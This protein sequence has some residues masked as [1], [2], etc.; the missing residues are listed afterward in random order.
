MYCPGPWMARRT[1]AP[2]AASAMSCRCVS[3]HRQRA[4]RRYEEA[5]AKQ[6]QRARRHASRRSNSEWSITWPPERTVLRE[7]SGLGWGLGIRVEEPPELRC[8]PGQ[9]LFPVLASTFSPRP[10]PFAQHRRVAAARL[11]LAESKGAR[12]RPSSVRRE[13]AVR[14]ERD[15][16]LLADEALVLLFAAIPQ[17]ASSNALLRRPQCRG[18]GRVLGVSPQTVNATE[19][20]KLWLV[21]A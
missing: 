18:N 11:S 2:A 6:G 4:N 10:R 9:V 5:V 21:R 12:G 1:A 7:G 17:G 13:L 19:L 20:A 8:P 16:D 14:P 15:P 3:A